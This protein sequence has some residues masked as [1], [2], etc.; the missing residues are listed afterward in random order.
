MALTT[1]L[2]DVSETKTKYTPANK[3][4]AKMN[5]EEFFNWRK[6]HQGKTAEQ[7]GKSWT[8]CPHHKKEGHY[9][10][11]YYSNHTPKTHDAWKAKGKRGR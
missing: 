1:A 10:G 5:D 2:K 4:Q 8:W 3:N 7:Q 6:T 9:D 11:L